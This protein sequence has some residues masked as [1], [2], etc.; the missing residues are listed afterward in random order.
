MKLTVYRQAVKKRPNGDT[1]YKGEDALPFAGDHI[2]LVADGLGGASAIRHQNFKPELFDPDAVTRTLF[3]ELYQDA[4]HPDFDRYVRDSFFELSAV[5]DIY[6]ENV[7]NI[8]KSGYFGSRIVSSILL[9]RFLLSEKPFPV[10]KLFDHVEKLSGAQLEA[11]LASY[12]ESC[13]M[14]VQDHLRFVGKKAGLT[15]ESAYEGLSLL[16]TTLTLILYREKEDCVQTILF[17][18]G[19]SRP[20]VWTEKDGLCQ[21]LPDEEGADGGMTNYIRANEDAFFHINCHY[22]TFAK[23]CILF[24]ASDGCFDSG[25]FLSPMAFEKL[26]E[27]SA[28]ASADPEE[29]SGRLKEFFLEAGRHDDSSTIAMGMFGYDSFTDLKAAMSR[30]LR[31]L[32]ETYLDKMPDLLE[33]DF[34]AQAKEAERKGTLQ[35]TPEL[36]AKADLQQ[37]LFDAYEPGYEKYM[38]QESPFA[39][40]PVPGEMAP[41]G[42]QITPFTPPRVTKT[43]EHALPSGYLTPGRGTVIFGAGS[44]GSGSGIVGSPSSKT[45]EKK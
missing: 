7:N 13:A 11:A 36:A 15:Y 21:I 27:E 35:E 20:Y 10:E 8:K 3:G 19:D 41:S 25:Y 44:A 43:S 26:L 23:P 2:L 40:A 31:T 5:R 9:H 33:E 45:D 38:P 12:G 16:G 18:A 32:Q 6:T 39:D 17:T 37:K 29:M 14:L 4:D 1:V 22:F 42:K 30:R 24:G 28:C 34:I